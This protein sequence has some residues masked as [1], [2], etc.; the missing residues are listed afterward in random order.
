MWSSRTFEGLYPDL[1]NHAEIRAKPV[2][3]ALRGVGIVVAG[4]GPVGGAVID[5]V[6]R[7]ERVFYGLLGEIVGAGGPDAVQDAVHGGLGGDE[8]APEVGVDDVV[9]VAGAGVGVA[10]GVGGGRRAGDDDRAGEVGD[11]G[12]YPAAQGLAE[13]AVDH[14]MGRGEIPN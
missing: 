9:P 12:A 3:Q 6:P 7:V 8:G 11:L 2:C 5:P 1:M 10:A 13:F 14:C 4:A